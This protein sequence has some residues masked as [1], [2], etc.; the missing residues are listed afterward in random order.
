MPLARQERPRRPAPLRALRALRSAGLR[1]L[2]CTLGAP[3]APEF[4]W[5]LAR[6]EA[7]HSFRMMRGGKRA[8]Q[9]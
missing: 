8:P 6:Q 3:A 1:G 5:P 2:R 9:D 4:F 7:K